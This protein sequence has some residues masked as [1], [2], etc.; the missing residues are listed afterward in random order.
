[1]G[2]PLPTQVLWVSNIGAKPSG[3]AQRLKRAHDN[4]THPATLAMPPFQQ[5]PKVQTL[6]VAKQRGRRS[7]SSLS[8]SLNTSTET[9]HGSEQHK[10]L[11]WLDA[12]TIIQAA[13]T[14]SV[15]Q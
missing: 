11:K 2:S 3:V 6:V 8:Q 5:P 10:T 13:T 15:M 7:F 12:T 14:K 9:C 4:D 1:M